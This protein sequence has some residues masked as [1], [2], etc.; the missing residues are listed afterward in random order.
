MATQSY[1]T[2]IMQKY[3]EYLQW[4]AN[5][6]V[7]LRGEIATVYVPEGTGHAVTEP[8]LLMKV[9]DGEKKFSE[10]PWLSAP[11]SDVHE[12]A[13]AANKPQYEAKEITG[14]G[15]YIAQYVDETLGISVDTDTQYRINKTDDYI[16]VLQSKA[17]G[18]DDAAFKDVSTIVIPKYD[19][20]TVNANIAALQELVG[21]T[22][23]AT[24]I[25]NAIAELDLANTY[26]A[27]GEAA[28]VQEALNAYEEANDAV[29]AGIKNGET[30]NDFKAVEDAL[31]AV[32]GDVEEIL[33][34]YA[35]KEEA[36]GYADAKDEAIAAAK[37]A[38]DDAAAALE[39]YKTA[40]DEAVQAAADAAAA[41]QETADEKVASVTAGDAS[42]TV[43]G[44]ATA[45]TVAAKLSQDAD[46]ALT[47][48]EDGLKVVIPAAAEYTIEKSADSG[49]YAAV[50]ALKK[51]GV[52]VGASINIPKDMV[53]ESGA[54][55]EN[56][57]GQ[58]E[59]T[60]IELRLQ[61]VAD[62]LYINVGNLIEYVTSG[63]ATGDMVVINISDDH[64]VTA[65]ITD[66]SITLAK[67]ATE[68]QTAVGKAHTHE[69][70]DV[71]AGINADKVAAWDAA[72]Q[73]AKDHANGLDEAMDARMQVVE[74]KAHE[75][76]F[77]EAEL[78]KIGDGDVA[79][80][81]AA[82][83]NAEATAAGALAEAK[84]ELEGKIAD[85]QA[86]AEKVAND[87]N[88]AMDTRV[89]V[90]EEID[91][92]AYIAA[93]EKVLED[94]QGYTDE[95]IKE[96]E[97]GAIAGLTEKDGEL[98]G[99]IADLDE[100]VGDL[101]EGTE[102]TTVVGYVDEKVG[103]L[104]GELAAIAKTGNVADLIQTEGDCIIFNCGTASTVMNVPAAQ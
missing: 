56:P 39:T 11:A 3:D 34:D 33:E 7:L 78:N 79:K 98:E 35:T 28:K 43:G 4:I 13:K 66:G 87:N 101:P 46:N 26:E 8:T 20:T 65:T 36:Q 24:Q 44:T 62:P 38:G 29:I 94:A 50:Y 18:E 76:T 12:W 81:N 60:Y 47:L 51:D 19:D 10:L 86:A 74:G 25:A 91:H 70:A 58:A 68:I 82:Q 88:T 22:A 83:A 89:K 1:N 102:A 77:N 21:E 54:V 27:K 53:V 16:Y 55:V 52:Q 5:D 45:P 42:V 67:L 80:W 103:K 73:N 59:G 64:K 90:L 40:N 23:V 95:Q 30:I 72:E 41:A 97:E 71:L 85:A 100:K 104:D 69:N 31:A 32:G 84:T 75:H 49:D 93:D 61:N 48:A 96:L 6:P 17:K 63:S 99:L 15:E 14:I 2:R 92:D 57:A 37:K 9:G